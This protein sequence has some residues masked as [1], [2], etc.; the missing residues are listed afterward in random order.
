MWRAFQRQLRAMTYSEPAEIPLQ[1]KPIY[2]FEKFHFCECHREFKSAFFSCSWMCYF[3]S[4]SIDFLFPL[5]NS[6][7][8]CLI[9]PIFSYLLLNISLSPRIC[10][11]AAQTLEIL[12][13]SWSALFLRTCLA[14]LFPFLSIHLHSFAVPCPLD[15]LDSA[16]L[17]MVD[18][19]KYFTFWLPFFALERLYIFIFDDGGLWLSYQCF[20]KPDDQFL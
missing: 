1:P 13:T 2:T 15:C 9:P 3:T 4:S 7:P 6:L 14:S 10:H 16:L 19:D 20:K 11:P 12:P 17:K 8:K 5:R 18:S